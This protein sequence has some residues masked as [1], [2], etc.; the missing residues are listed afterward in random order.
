MI[1]LGANFIKL[2]KPLATL[3]LIFLLRV[4]LL[5][6]PRLH[7]PQF[8]RLT[9]VDAA[10]VVAVAVEV[11]AAHNTPQDSALV[12]T[13]V[14]CRLQC[15]ATRTHSK[16]PPSPPHR[17]QSSTDMRTAA[18]PSRLAKSSRGRHSWMEKAGPG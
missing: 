2:F 8:R 3:V 17:A 12:N 4:V 13:G 14:P 6:N 15:S 10:W 11:K 18:R 5:P 16:L 9:V 7:R 1:K